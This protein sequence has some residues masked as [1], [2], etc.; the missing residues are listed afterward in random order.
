MKLHIFPV[1]SKEARLNY[2]LTIKNK[3]RKGLLEDYMSNLQKNNLREEGNP[4]WGV[5]SCHENK[6]KDIEY[7]DYALFYRNF[8]LFS[9]G[10]IIYKKNDLAL[11]QKLWQHSSIQ[12]QHVIVL[13]SVSYIDLPTGRLA[14]VLNDYSTMF[15]LSKT[16]Q[17]TIKY[18]GYTRYDDD[19]SEFLVKELNFNQLLGIEAELVNIDP[20]E[21]GVM[22]GKRK[23]SLHYKIER[24]SNIIK[25]KKLEEKKNKGS[26]AC[27][28]CNFNFEKKYGAK[29]RDYIECHHNTPLSRIKYGSVTKLSDLSLLCANCH[30]MIHRK[31]G[32]TKEELSKIYNKY[33]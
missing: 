6:I 15:L 26:L 28:I 30:R 7:G 11:A 32:C 3:V 20:K 29:G 24:N 4:V 13:E 16:Y 25:M 27:E 23:L 33:K 10:R 18:M 22:E 9:I 5:T 14:K 21:K 2:N 8:K 17:S 19:I 31:H 12:Y 1:S